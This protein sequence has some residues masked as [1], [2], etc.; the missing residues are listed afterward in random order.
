MRILFLALMR[1]VTIKNE[2]GDYILSNN[3]YLNET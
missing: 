2:G 1:G 3:F